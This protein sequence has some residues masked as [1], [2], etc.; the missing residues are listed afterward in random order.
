MLL[1]GLVLAIAGSLLAAAAPTLGWLVAA[2]TLQGAGTAAGMV[3]GRALVQDLFTGRERTRMMAFVGMTMGVVPPL[4]MLVGGQMHV[5][6]GWQANFLVL[7][8]LGIVLMAGAL[9]GLP[10]AKPAPSAASAG[11]SALFTGYLQLLR[12]PAFGLYVVLLSSMTASFYTFLAGTPIVLR[13]YGV[14]P[15]KVGLYV[16]SV[17]LSYIAGNVL[18]TRLIHRLGDRS[19]MALGQA[20]SCGALVGVLGLAAAGW[21]TPLALTVPLMLLG[22][23]HGLLVPPALTGTVGLVPA[24]AGSA[25]AVAG[26][27]QQLTGAF[28]GFAVGLFT[29]QGPVNLGLLMLGWTLLGLTAQVLLFRVVMKRKVS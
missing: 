24:L 1:A 22:I 4:A 10:D 27:T 21:L 20:A 26:L 12:T 13:G 18:T 19:I 3:I 5:R 11:W 7:A 25:A 29:H 14:T 17:P 8:G 16:M 23:G 28:G 15:E 9:R 2:R 6:L